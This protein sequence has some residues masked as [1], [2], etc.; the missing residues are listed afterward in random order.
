MTMRTLFAW[1]LCFNLVS[2]QVLALE[3]QS[4]SLKYRKIAKSIAM[5]MNIGGT[6]QDLVKRLELEDSKKA[7]M[8]Q[9]LKQHKGLDKKI[10][11][12]GYRDNTIT[13]KGVQN[14]PPLTIE[15]GPS[16]RATFNNKSTVLKGKTLISI[17]NE[18]E[19]FLKQSSGKA[20]RDLFIP[21]LH[22]IVWAAVPFLIITVGGSLTTTAGLIYGTYRA[23]KFGYD[24]ATSDISCLKSNERLKQS[25]LSFDLSSLNCNN[26]GKPTTAQRTLSNASGKIRSVVDY[27]YQFA[28]DRL[29]QVDKKLNGA[30]VCSYT[31]NDKAEVTRVQGTDPRFCPPSVGEDIDFATSFPHENAIACC[32]S[33][34]RKEIEAEIHRIQQEFNLEV[35]VAESPGTPSAG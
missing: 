26:Q 30:I 4:E 7:E 27:N 35:P 23:V 24:C 17:H 19:T 32:A 22:A 29:Q 20:G 25:L 3:N 16:P 5:Q 10:P 12:I 28:A 18:L 13:L 1:I 8:L 15:L 14:S 31:L 34:C 21:D 6:F 9:Y 11:A 2:S 33:N